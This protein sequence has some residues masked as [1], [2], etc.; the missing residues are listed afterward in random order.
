M[1]VAFSRRYLRRGPAFDA[2]LG[3]DGLRKLFEFTLSSVGPYILSVSG[4][5]YRMVL[6]FPLLTLSSVGRPP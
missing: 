6:A 4:S 2:A 5:R 1:C 3:E